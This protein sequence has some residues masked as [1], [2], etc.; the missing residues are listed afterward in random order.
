M[1]IIEKEIGKLTEYE[2]NSRTHSDEQIQQIIA[3]INEFG[4]TNPLLINSDNG[5]IAG[6]GRLRAAIEAGMDKVPCIILK[7]LTKAQER[8]YVIADNKIAINAGWDVD[9]L[10]FELEELKAFDFDLELMGF[11][12]DLLTKLMDIDADLPTI[13][14]GD[15]DL[16][17]TKTFTL[18]DDQAQNVDDAITL[19]RT[20]PL[21]DT[22]I[23]ENSNGNALALICQQ[24]L[25]QKNV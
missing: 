21:S 24:W 14:D 20:S 18:H 15:R 7:G 11:D 5:V 13:P 10:R 12:S 25:D 16:F 9:V 2:N 4:F 22:G 23:N 1:E 8:A 17:Q 19:A 3:S 6:H